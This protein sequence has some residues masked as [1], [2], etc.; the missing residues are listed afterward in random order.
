MPRRDIP[1]VS[2]EYYHVY[3]RGNNRGD[4]FFEPENYTF[5][6]RRLRE[7]LVK[8]PPAPVTIMAYCL[9]PNHFHLIIQPHDDDL[10]YH[11]QMFGISFAKA[12]NDR[13]RRVGSLFQGTFKAKRVDR[14]EYLL[15]LSRYIHLNPVRAGLTARPEEWAFSSYRE[16]VGL[17]HGTLPQ[18]EIVLGQFATRQAYQEFVD[19]YLPPD[20][21]RV[22]HLMLDDD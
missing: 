19:L 21:K 17:R 16:Y 2:G 11:M 3:N 7:Y 14:D 20:K 13:Y 9:M 15:H 4:I 6:L 8:Q 10:S 22:A 18:P 1:L 5:F 12:I